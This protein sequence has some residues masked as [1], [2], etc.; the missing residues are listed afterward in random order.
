MKVAF[1]VRPSRD[2]GYLI[3]LRVT[4]GVGEQYRFSTGQKVNDIKNWT[5]ENVKRSRS[6]PNALQ[7]NHYLSKL[8][9]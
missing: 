5:G 6:E 7:T 8:K 3:N 4:L 2:K 1:Y 9:N